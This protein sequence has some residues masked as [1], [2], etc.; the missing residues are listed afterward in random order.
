MVL[1]EDFK[2]LKY[3]DLHNY[4]ILMTLITTLVD[5]KIFTTA[6]VAK[7]ADSIYKYQIR[8]QILKDLENEQRQMD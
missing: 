1:P 8:P 2:D 6:E 4:V 5:L 7:N 3:G